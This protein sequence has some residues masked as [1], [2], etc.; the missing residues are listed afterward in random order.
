MTLNQ[1]IRG[2]QD[3]STIGCEMTDEGEKSIES[4]LKS[5][6]IV[7]IDRRHIYLKSNHED[8]TITQLH[9]TTGMI[10]D[11]TTTKNSDEMMN[12][13][14]TETCQ[15]YETHSGTRCRVT[16]LKRE[17]LYEGLSNTSK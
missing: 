13:I 17:C 2:H 4:F 14:L 16:L 15:S 12:T 9:Q 10:A 11:E 1:V 3:I 8:W 7:C 6:L 5:R